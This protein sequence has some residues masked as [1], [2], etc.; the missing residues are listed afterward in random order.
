MGIAMR[1]FY[2]AGTF[3]AYVGIDF[4]DNFSFGKSTLSCLFRYLGHAKYHGSFLRST[5]GG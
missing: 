5:I 2:R 4:G 1:S 3:L